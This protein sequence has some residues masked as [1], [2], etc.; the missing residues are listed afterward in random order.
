MIAQEEITKNQDNTEK[1][2]KWHLCE[3]FEKDVRTYGWIEVFVSDEVHPF[4]RGRSPFCSLEC[5]R[6]YLD[7]HKNDNMRQV[8]PW[9]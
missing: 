8:A 5:L 1:K 6:L 9:L 7:Y 2:C 3:A 4:S